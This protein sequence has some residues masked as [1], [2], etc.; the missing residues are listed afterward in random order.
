ME[1]IGLMAPF[2]IERARAPGKNR[3]LKMLAVKSAILA[4]VLILNWSHSYSK[5][6][7]VNFI[8]VQTSSRRCPLPASSSP[9]LCQKSSKM[10]CEPLY[11]KWLCDA[12][13]SR[14]KRKMHLHIQISAIQI[15]HCILLMGKGAQITRYSSCLKSKM[16]WLLRLLNFRRKK[17]YNKLE[18]DMHPNCNGND[19]NDGKVKG[20]VADLHFLAASRNL[21]RRGAHTSAEIKRDIQQL[22]DA[23]VARNLH[24]CGLLWIAGLSKN[25]TSCSCCKVNVRSIQPEEILADEPLC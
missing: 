20:A 17:P 14:F 2:V 19:T 7:I 15:N 23:F 21:H 16:N 11:A 24:E 22:M 25:V 3:N 18:E 4:I 1:S 13:L 9:G 6:Q 5:V 8:N 12:V 10:Y